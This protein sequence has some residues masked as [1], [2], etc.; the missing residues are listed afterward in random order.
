[1]NEESIDG[2]ITFNVS[3]N[4][5]GKGNEGLICAFDTDPIIC[6]SGNPFQAQCS[7]VKEEEF[8]RLHMKV[9]YILNNQMINR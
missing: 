3:R 9:S 8:Y 7:A 1:M 4:G 6:C 5:I 2:P